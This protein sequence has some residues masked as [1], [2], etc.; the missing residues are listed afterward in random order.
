MAARVIAAPLFSG[1]R[2]SG[3]DG[4]YRSVRRQRVLENSHA[5]FS[6]AATTLPFVELDVQLSRDGVPVVYHDWL[7]RLDAR[8]ARGGGDDVALRIPIGHLSAAQLRAISVLPSRCARGLSRGAADVVSEKLWAERA[9]AAERDGSGCCDAGCDGGSGARPAGGGCSH[10]TSRDALVAAARRRCA[11]LGVDSSAQALARAAETLD[12]H[13]LR[14]DERGG[15]PALADVLARLDIRCGVNIELKYPEPY[16]ISAFGLRVASPDVF[17]AT[18][19]RVVAAAKARTIMFSS[20]NPAVA[21][22]SRAAAG[23]HHCYFLTSACE[24]EPDARMQSLE[25][26]FAFATA[27]KLHGVVT[28]VAPVLRDP[29]GAIGAAHQRG[30]RIATY[31]QENNTAEA[32]KVQ[33]DAGVDM[34]ILDDARVA[35]EFT[36]R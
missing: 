29:G 32:V 3:A 33:A 26:A 17:V 36:K 13:G 18:I 21:A 24:D 9:D 11:A 5:S 8:G 34:V 6:L 28:H 25:A 12:G 19:M 16:E 23:A 31:G 1:H 2:G 7:V 4:S 22:A 20:F 27:N 15:I 14:G 10:A 35:H 30:L